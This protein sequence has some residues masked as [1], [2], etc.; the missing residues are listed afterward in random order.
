MYTPITAN[1]VTLLKR[2]AGVAS[3]AFLGLILFAPSAYG[4]ETVTGTVVDSTTGQSLAGAN[5]AVKGTTIGTATGAD[6]EYRL[7]VSSLQDTLLVS[8]VGYRTKQ[9]PIDGQNRIDVALTETVLQGE[10]VVVVGYERVR[11]ENLTSSVSK[12]SSEDLIQGSATSVAQL[13]RGR[14]PGLTINQVGSN[15]ADEPSLKLRGTGTLRGDS[16]PL[17]I[18]DGVEGSLESISPHDIESI[19]VIKDGSAAAIYGTRGSNGVVVVET[20]RPDGQKPTLNFDAYTTSQQTTQEI[21]VLSAERF[22]EVAQ[23]NVPGA[24][25]FGSSTDW[26]DQVMRD[27]PLSQVY[28]LRL[29][30][31]GEQTDYVA[32][33]NHERR[34]GLM[35]RSNNKVLRGRIRVNHTMFD[36]DLQA[37]GNFI[38][39]KE[40]RYD[41]N[42]AGG[43]YSDRILRDVF[44]YNPTRPIFNEDGS[45]NENADNN[46]DNPVSLLRETNGEYQ[47][48]RVKF[49]G[50]LTYSPIENL[51]LKA[52][53]SRL[54]VDG[55]EGYSETKAHVLSIQ[56]G[57]NGYA[58][59]RTEKTVEQILNLTATYRNSF[60][61]HNFSVL[62]G[63]TWKQNE[64]ENFFASNYNFP[65]DQVRYNNLSDG[66]AL[67]EGQASMD[68]YKQKSNL[69]GY[70]GRVTY[71]YQNKY[72]LTASFR[73]EASSKF[74]AN[75]KWGLFPALSAGWVLSRESFLEDVEPI[76]TLKIRFG[77][78]V[79]GSEP[80]SPYQS[81]SRLSFGSNVLVGDEWIS[82]IQ[83]LENPNPNLQW[84]EK[85]EYNV[86]LDFGFF[87]DRI[88]GSVDVYQKETSDL[89]FPFTVP[90]P[91]YLFDTILANAG[92]IRNRGIEVL[93]SATLLS[94]ETFEWRST[95]T[96][97]TNNNKLVS[98]SD[99]RFS[100]GRGFFDVG[101]TGAPIQQSTHRVRIG[102]QIGNY[103]GYKTV[104]VTD[105]GF[106]RI[107]G[108]DGEAK[109]ITEQTPEDKQVIGNGVPNHN[110]S[111]GHSL[112]YGNW[113][114]EVTMRGAFGF[115][116]LN[117]RR[118]YYNVPTQ[119]KGGNVMQ[120]T[121][122]PVFGNRPLSPNQSKQYVS[123][124]VEDGDFWKIDNVT[125]GYNVDTQGISYLQQ[126]R[127]YA[128]ADNLYTITGYS[129]FDPDVNFSGLTP[130][131]DHRDRYPTTRRFTLGVNF[132]F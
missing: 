72:L 50:S 81:L 84:E 51:D 127:I 73:R 106:W 79:T 90:T 70:F 82:T 15:P 96:Y 40:W 19:N 75:N 37:V 117:L 63:Y 38:G 115:Q 18:I 30:S 131:F 129:G 35:K 68:S 66:N 110:L 12:V 39:M 97:S 118:M 69:L 61:G 45:Y 44:A 109:P 67:P 1:A 32:A 64:Y 76:S 6:G 43:S 3:L 47:E 48:S 132:T 85:T 46:S 77:Y 49:F 95:A 42:E 2:I 87:D 28:N 41:G 114:A 119:A 130:G 20:K 93:T 80:T 17:V 122:D 36:G 113:D 101:S 31:A 26:G 21:P 104:G 59:R 24:T 53:G 16:S 124:F 23:S 4:Q 57:L 83:P 60:A 116:I 71:D 65:T 7:Q 107:E 14:V 103:Y 11:Q 108:Q 9:I 99:N 128:S 74:G 91:P 105:D 10:D 111:W 86:G 123:Y 102:G 126:A 58:S 92:T 8:Y 33:V 100:L 34:E 98:L 121:F 112:S 120:G 88:N 13:I 54:S 5:V 78:G 89:L 56:N 55:L 52:Q 29:S 22:R 27:M 62:G 125:L 25:D 94:T